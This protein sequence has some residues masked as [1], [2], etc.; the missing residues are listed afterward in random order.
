[1][2]SLEGL[3]IN[4]NL[5]RRSD[6]INQCHHVWRRSFFRRHRSGSLDQRDFYQRL[7][8]RNATRADK[9]EVNI[10]S[11]EIFPS[12][13]RIFAKYYKVIEAR[14][15]LCYFFKNKINKISKINVIFEDLFDV[16]RH[17]PSSEKGSFFVCFNFQSFKLKTNN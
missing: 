16:E 1:M 13:Q 4:E 15:T 17:R 3:L 5:G 7:A 9:M 6:S 10:G 11:P 8:Q 14:G 2:G 12:L